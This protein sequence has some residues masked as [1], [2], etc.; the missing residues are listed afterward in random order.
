MAS[1]T[2]SS[3]CQ[4]C[5]KELRSDSA[6][7]R[8]IAATPKCKVLWEKEIIGPSSHVNLK[9][10]GKSASAHLEVDDSAQEHPDAWDDL[11]A[12]VPEPSP[13][14]AACGE[15]GGDDNLVHVRKNPDTETRRYVEAYP[16]P[17]GV[18][19]GQG[20]TKFEELHEELERLGQSIYAPF[21]NEEEWELAQWLSRRVGQKAIDEYLKLTIVSPGS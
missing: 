15:E 6:M 16:R 5:H 14:P 2:S 21:A 8:H 10:N 12:F 7:K 3:R 20:K 13:E 1:R 4:F 19:I 18:P 17:V 9:S 11:L